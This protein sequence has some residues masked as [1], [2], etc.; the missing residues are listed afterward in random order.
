MTRAHDLHHNPS[1][2]AGPARRASLLTGLLLGALLLGSG[3][4]DSGLTVTMPSLRAADGAGISFESLPDRTRVMIDGALFTEYRH[5]GLA[6]PVLFPLVGPHGERLTRGWPL[7]EG[8]AGE[9]HDHPHHESLWFT[10]GSVNGIDF[11]AKAKGP[12]P[13]AAGAEPIPRIVQNSLEATAPGARPMALESTN[14]W[15]AP[16]GAVVC[17]DTRR[18]AFSAD[19]TGRT[20]DV[21]VTLHA[22]QGPVTLGDTKEGTMALRVVSAL[23]PKDANGSTGAA[24]RIVNS[25][26]QENAA[27][28]GKPA[29]WV[30][31]SGTV[32]GHAVGIAIL[33]HPNNLRHP[34][35]W[36]ARDYGLFAANPFGLHDFTGAAKGSGDHTIPAGGSLTLR[37]RIVIHDGDAAAAGIE[38]RWRDWT[39]AAP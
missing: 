9:A 19:D 32:G 31:Y 16:D 8:V 28:W 7:E 34:T 26:G 21:A 11:W 30:D 36:H 13:A 24:G 35:C 2:A 17:T 27:A 23:Q 18:F 12:W 14:T 3:L 38:G 20:I 22:D 25:A 1:A 4:L 10:H 33:D 6:K 15:V 37:Y 5:G 39:G 29:R